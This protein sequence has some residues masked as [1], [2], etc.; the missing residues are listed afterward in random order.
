MQRLLPLAFLLLLAA[1][2]HGGTTPAPPNNGSGNG[3]G[4]GTGSGTAAGTDPYACSVDDDCMAVELECCDA[5]NGGKAVGVNK[6]HAS[7]VGDH[8]GKDSCE[9]V[10]CTEMACPPWVATCANGRC[11][12][13]RGSF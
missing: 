8:S 13:A 5:C 11:E 2:K 1:C 6:A 7:E 9:G 3:S 12:I 10:M 4:T